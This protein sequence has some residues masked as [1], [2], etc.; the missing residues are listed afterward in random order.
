MLGLYTVHHTK[1]QRENT[2][3]IYLYTV[4]C[5]KFA[6]KFHQNLFFAPSLIVQQLLIN[7]IGKFH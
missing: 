1:N 2:L 7:E 3:F 4:H 6:L 5:K